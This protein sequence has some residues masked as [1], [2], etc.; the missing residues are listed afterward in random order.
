MPPHPV[1]PG[2]SFPQLLIGWDAR[3]LTMMDSLFTELKQGCEKMCVCVSPGK[4][5][6]LS[7]VFF[8]C[9]F[10]PC[11]FDFFMAWMFVLFHSSAPLFFQR[12]LPFFSLHRG[13]LT[14]MAFGH[15]FPSLPSLY[16]SPSLIILLGPQTCVNGAVKV[17]VWLC[18]HAHFCVQHVKAALM[19]KP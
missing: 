6:V 5:V 15:I 14:Y 18:M 9:C 4:V 12:F 8:C 3:R 10:W 11:L 13:L 1:P 16:F 19:Y 7:L 17:R 2:N